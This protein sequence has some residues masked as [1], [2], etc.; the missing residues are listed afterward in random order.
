MYTVQGKL[1]CDGKKLVAN[2]GWDFG[3]Y[4]FRLFPKYFEITRQK[5]EAHVTIVRS[6]ER[7]EFKKNYTGRIDIDYDPMVYYD[8]PYYF[9]KC[10]SKQ[11]G[12]IRKEL[13]LPE[14]RKPFD[15]YHITIANTK[16]ERQ[17]L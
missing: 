13:G 12:E 9:L 2:L 8:S 16:F 4:Y 17:K 11:I 14:Y 1:Y 15:Y 6:F 10:W 3:N 7:A 5:F